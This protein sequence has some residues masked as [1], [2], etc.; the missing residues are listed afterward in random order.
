MLDTS[1]LVNITQKS[2]TYVA[3]FEVFLHRGNRWIGVDRLKGKPL[4]DGTIKG[5]SCQEKSA[6]DRGTSHVDVPL[7][8]KIW[9]L[10]DIF[11]GV[12]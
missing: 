4:G 8:D 1:R 6:W 3:V 7:S 11:A 12:R 2:K 9:I 5:L 10:S